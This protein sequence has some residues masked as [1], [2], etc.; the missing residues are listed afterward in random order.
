MRILLIGPTALDSK[1]N[2]IKQRKLHLPGLTLP[3]LAAVTPSHCE[4]RLVNETVEDIPFAEHW[5]LVGITGM[6]SGIVRA[7]QIADEFK[8]RGATAVIG[9]IAASLLG[10]ELSLEH[11]DSVVT[12]EAE[13][14]WP[15]LINDFEHSRL[16]PVYRMQRPPPI[17]G[18]PL[19]RYDLMNRSR[20][21]FWRPV[22]ATR[23][24][25]FT[26]NYC[27]IT[28][29][30]KAGYRKRPVAEV[31]RD[32]RAAK[33]SGTRYIAFIDDNIGVDFNYC[34]ELWE[35]LI[36]EKI[37]WISQ[38]SLHIAD[39]P[40]MLR[41]AHESGCRL[42]SFGI[43]TT[44]AESLKSVDKEWNRPERYAS[45]VAAIRKHGIDV[46]T[47]M[48]IGLDGDDASVFQKTYD[49]IMDNQISVPRVHI[50]TPIPGTP[51]YEELKRDGRIV[52]MDFSRFSGGQV[53]YRPRNIKP[54]ELQTGYWRLYENLFSWGAIK[55]R[56]A[57][58]RASLGPYM[59]AFVLGVNLHYRRHVLNRIC[60]GIV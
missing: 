32:V 58:N 26:C 9:G 60:P 5:D 13:E 27:S 38:C 11:A 39:R 10:P 56:I 40:D 34:A 41:L 17:E 37:I 52:S 21:G 55:R 46:S 48:I 20:L 7:W 8:R 16:K 45:A 6:G 47:E 31:V 29:F 3:M 44:S 51:L 42:L 15:Q 28:A 25:P 53:T 57:G 23:G 30:F 18:L 33:Q 54:D 2:P 36:P 4:L 24:C 1:G 59:R 14:I 43:E 49:F 35:A 22:Q 50:M 19:P 12:G